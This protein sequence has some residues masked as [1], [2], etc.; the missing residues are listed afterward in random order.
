MSHA[1][2]G[3]QLYW[4]SYLLFLW[5]SNLTGYSVFLFHVAVLLGDSG[6]TL[7]LMYGQLRMTQCDAQATLERPR[8]H[9]KWWAPCYG[10]CSGVGWG[11][12]GGGHLG[13]RCLVQRDSEKKTPLR[14]GELATC[15]LT[16]L[17]PIQYSE[18]P[19]RRL[20]SA[21]VERTSYP[22]RPGVMDG[23]S[24][25]VDTNPANKVSFRG[26]VWLEEALC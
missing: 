25:L 20:P 24:Q 23:L 19:W 18:A 12:F 6:S 8:L 1:I 10:V 9:S 16:E 5:N 22:H 2:F 15:V 26:L 11:P 3:A 14:W 7:G 17:C 21:C 13:F 4:N